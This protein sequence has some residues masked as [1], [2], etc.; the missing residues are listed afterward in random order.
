M[1]TIRDLIVYDP[2][3]SRRVPL[4]ANTVTRSLMKRFSA[5][6]TRRRVSVPAQP[7]PPLTPGLGGRNLWNHRANALLG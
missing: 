4:P 5:L 2:E 7:K 1:C 6:L 3:T